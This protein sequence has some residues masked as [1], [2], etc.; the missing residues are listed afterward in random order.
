MWLYVGNQMNHILFHTQCLFA[1]FFIGFIGFGQTAAA[2]DIVPPNTATTL[3]AENH[4]QTDENHANQVESAAVLETD[5]SEKSE[6]A[7]QMLA[8]FDGM[9]AAVD[10]QTGNCE[11]M[12]KALQNYYHEH[13]A[14]IS[15]LDYATGNLDAETM[16]AVHEKAV[17]FGK[18]L[19]VCYDQKSIPAQ[20]HRYAGMGEEFE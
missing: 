14:W 10:A 19:S 2:Q 11:A 7:R 5:K 8:F 9:I 1:A 3:A 6:T 15:S 18:K 4:A 17:A 20:L 12:S 16:A 13:Q